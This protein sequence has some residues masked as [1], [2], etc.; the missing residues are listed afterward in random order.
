M[1][2]MM[3]GVRKRFGS[4]L[5]P[6]GQS[7]ALTTVTASSVPATDPASVVVGG[8]PLAR[9]LEI[10]VPQG[11]PAAEAVP[12]DEGV[13]G[14]VSSAGS[15]TQTALDGRFAGKAFFRHEQLTGLSYHES[16]VILGSTTN[17]I[18][19]TTGDAAILGGGRDL[20][21][22]VIG[23]QEGNVNNFAV[24]NL[25]ADST[26]AFDYS[27]II[28]GYDN[29]NNALASY[30]AGMH[31]LISANGGGGGGP[32]GGH[33]SIFGGSLHKILAGAYH[34]IFGGTNHTINATGNS[35]TVAGGQ[36]HVVGGAFAG[37][38]AGKGNT[39][40]GDYSLA[41][42]GTNNTAT[43]GSSTVLGGNT[44]V[45]SALGSLAAG[46]QNTS[47]TDNAVALGFQSNP[48]QEGGLAVA[49]GQFAARGDAQSETFTL[50]RLTTTATTTGLGIAGSSTPA[51]IDPDTL[52]A[53]TALVV[54]QN[55]N[56]A[57]EE[58][59]AW[60]IEGAVRRPA[61]GSGQ[62]LGTP[63]ITSLGN[64]AGAA[65]WSVAMAVGTSAVYINVTGEAGKSIRWVARMD[66][67]QVQG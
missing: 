4:L 25:P 50:R 34:S 52:W 37:A 46:R 41:L 7:A 63:T 5:G 45:A 26:G 33:H 38:F 49:N 17:A 35:A 15:A 18:N 36:D 59:R 31:C 42:G 54:A 47:D 43:G 23:G 19:A 13:A 24:S 57:V 9:T 14:F 40:S 6:V 56:T 16:R 61:S 67:V 64:N 1:G 58:Q 29:V 44:N 3:A 12:Q 39:A 30:I 8:T 55:I 66:V 28:C 22:N 53:F 62:F 51:T 27:A 20:M 65:S 48:S 11:M 21:E 60:K 2:S 32:G 10:K